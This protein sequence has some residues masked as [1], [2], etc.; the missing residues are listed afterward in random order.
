VKLVVHYAEIGTKG[1]NRPRFE[2]CLRQN[3]ER[4][5]A[6]L[7]KVRTKRLFGRLLVELP[8]DPPASEL[9]ERIG[10]VFGVAYASVASSAPPA[11]E[12]ILALV[13]A[14]VASRRFASFG[15]RVRRVDKALPFRSHELA[16]ELG[17]RIQARTGA[18]VDLET[19]ELWVEL[20]LLHGEAIL[21]HERWPGPGGLPVR[22]AG[23]ALA[24]LS[25]GI[26]S[27]AAAWLL[28]KR[29]C[30]TSFA[31]F[32]S[33][34]YTSTASQR[35][36]RD[37]VAQLAR[38]QG[39]TRLWRVPFAELQQALVREAPAEPR[40]VLYRR[41]MLRIAQAL[42]ERDHAL[43]LVTGDSVGQVSSQTLAN[44]DT[45]NRAATLPVLR[46]LVGADKAEIIALAK[47]IGTYEI[48]IEPDEDCCSFLMP[49]QP[50]TWTRPEAI[51]AIE[52]NLDVKGLVESTLSRVEQERIEPIP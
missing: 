32:H 50:A 42:A 18:A 39:P 2:D 3:L 8:G 21:L 41:F 17:S 10:R 6:P 14:F 20:H 24:L 38:W 25:G 19:P 27:P 13:D 7:G 16:V 52:R 33:A 15:V 40:I 31:H 37:A 28:M 45:I 49:R 43:A 44:L 11:R 51:E 36:A 1:K 34:P 30:L 46:P 26:D 23:R 47:R 5:L 29:G 4:V 35:K 9:R 48:S 12:A 22:S